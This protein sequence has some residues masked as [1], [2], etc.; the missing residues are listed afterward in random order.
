MQ[1]SPDNATLHQDI[2]MN[3]IEL[4]KILDFCSPPYTQ[5]AVRSGMSTTARL[6]PAAPWGDLAEVMVA[7]QFA[8]LEGSLSGAALP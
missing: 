1:Q 7:T 4:L 5:V 2:S 6:P 8:A 3:K